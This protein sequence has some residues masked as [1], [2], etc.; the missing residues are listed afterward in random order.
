MHVI[1]PDVTITD[2]EDGVTISDNYTT[3]LLET[4]VNAN[5]GYRYLP[6]VTYGPYQLDSYDDSTKQAVLVINDSYLGTYDGVKPSIAKLILKSVTT[7]TEMDELAAGTVDLIGGVSGG[8]SI[9]A[10][11]DVC[12]EGKAEYASYDRAGYGKIAFSCDVGPTQFAAVRQAIAYCLDRDEFAKQYSGGYA[13]VVN[14]MYGLST[15]EYKK[16]KDTMDKE[17]NNYSKDL[18]KAK[19][20]LIDDGWTLNK[21]GNEFVEGTDDVRYKNVDGELMACEINWANTPNNPVSDLLNTMLPGEMAKIGMKLNP[22]TVELGVLLNEL[23]RIGIDEPTYNMFNLATGF[24]PISS[25]WYEYSNDPAYMGT[26]NTNFIDDEELATIAANMKKI[27]YENEEEWEEAW[28]NF[29]KRWNELL[30]DIPLY[31]DEYHDFYS[32]KIKGYEPDSLWQWESAIVYSY[33]EKADQ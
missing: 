33:I 11:L 8:D 20:L 21:D 25:L 6:K 27:P 10:G 15:P 29:Q 16:N 17:L 19:Q 26:W 9:N 31:S 18:E 5:D 32:T 2:S 4:T 3:E 14:G 13:K 30:P 22:T 23:Y 7:E 12:D 28:V 1:A 24:V